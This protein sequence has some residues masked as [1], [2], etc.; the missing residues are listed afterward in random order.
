MLQCDCCTAI[1]CMLHCDS[2]YAALQC[3]TCMLRFM[4]QCAKRLLHYAK[5]GQGG[6]GAGDPFRGTRCAAASGRYVAPPTRTATRLGLFCEQQLVLVFSANSDRLMA[7][8]YPFFGDP[9]QVAKMQSWLAKIVTPKFIAFN[10]HCWFAYA[11]VITLPFPETAPA[12]LVGAAIKEFYIDKH[13]E[14]GQTFIDNSQDF[15]GYVTGT[16][17]ALLIRRFR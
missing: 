13:Y 9:T 1:R 6:G 7:D 10:A 8:S 16:I 17:L 3:Y 14:N 11:V 12:V 5:E 15:L 2:L 4:L